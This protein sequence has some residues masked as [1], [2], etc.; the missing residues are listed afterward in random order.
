MP[1][2]FPMHG[3]NMYHLLTEIIFASIV[4]LSCLL[5]YLKTK[6]IYDLTGHKG[7]KYFR[8]AFLFFGLSYAFRFLIP[9]AALID[10]RIFL[11]REIGL[12]FSTYF[13]TLAI[14]SLTYSTLWKKLKRNRYPLLS[15]NVVAIALFTIVYFTV[16]P[17]ILLLTQLVLL[18]I[19][20]VGSYKKKKRFTQMSTVYGLLF[21][22]WVLTIGTLILPRFMFEAK[23][24]LYTLSSV[25]FVLMA[26]KVIKRMN[27]AKEKR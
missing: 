22:F 25:I 14:L 16:S 5:I 19:C 1:P 27:H 3:P 11:L 4:M 10:M 13:S 17:L 18:I 24:I 12:L 2:P 15:M 26:Y 20:I 21:L 6:E 23:V 9:Y 7:I 8:Y